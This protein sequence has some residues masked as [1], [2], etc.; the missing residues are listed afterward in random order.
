MSCAIVLVLALLPVPSAQEPTSASASFEGHWEGRIRM[1]E[2]D[3]DLDLRQTADGEWSG[4]LSIPVQAIADMQLEQLVIEVDSLEFALP[5]SIPGEARFTGSLQP[6]EEDGAATITGTLFQHGQKMPFLLTRGI[7]PIVAA[8][9]ALSDFDAWMKGKLKS[10]R[11]PGAAI[12]VV[13]RG[14]VILARGYGERDVEAQLPATADTLFAIGSTTKAFTAFALAQAVQRGELEW[15]APV[16][17][18]LPELDLVSDYAERHLT[19]RDMVSHRSGL[20]RHDLV[21]YLFPDKSRAD[22]VAALAHLEPTYELREQ[23]QYNNLM[24][25]TAGFALERVTGKSW[26]DNVREG[27]LNPLGMTNTA[28]GPIAAQNSSDFAFPYRRQGTKSVRI[29][30]RDLTAIG[31]AGSIHSSA[32]DMARWLQCWLAHGESADKR[33]LATDELAE[34]VKPIVALPAL[35]PDRE[36]SPQ[37][38]A[39]GWMI[40]NHRGHLRIQH[41]GAIDGFV[42]TVQLFPGDSTG[43]FVSTNS[44]SPL[45][46]LA[47][48]EVVERLFGLETASA[49][50]LAQSSLDQAE[51]LKAVGELGEAAARI[52]DA[53]PAHALAEYVG[54]YSHPGYGQ[55]HIEARED[56]GLLLRMG[57]LQGALEPWHYEVFRLDPEALGD[58]LGTLQ[59]QF[60]TDLAGFV[61]GLR[62]PLES[63]LD[64]IRFEREP[65]A[66][67]ADPQW[68]ARVVGDYTLPMASIEIRL[69]G[70]QLIMEVAGQ[71]PYRLEP[72]T[73]ERFRL[74]EVE[75][76]DVR[77]EQADG[78]ITGLLLHQ[79]NG[80]F[81][82]KR[83]Q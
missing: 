4:D 62:S 52:P 78:A 51:S 74:A 67:L 27:I 30:F 16:R 76:F 9:E 32:N 1:A 64:P 34:L 75:G 73:H 41:D 26:E 80:T 79:P 22:L 43:I 54:Q 5:D 35:S 39:M 49:S 60:E 61:S 31:P 47:A 44:S 50:E 65:D 66:E 83:K 20:P 3:F 40:D 17:T 29:P 42:A 8:K 38:Y 36:A 70:D 15:D 53:P 21:W 58:E 46:M 77:F 68:L 7:D 37:V 2:L 24:F 71:P 18:Y 59:V 72:W 23:W 13:V 48:E 69:E 81:L 45:A 56:G 11:V 55:V 33:L 25:L 28:F 10:F 14:E 57:T 12:C 19:L 63:S 6:A 82:A